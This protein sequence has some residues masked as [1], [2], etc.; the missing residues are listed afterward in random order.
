MTAFYPIHINIEGKKCLIVGGGKTAERKVSTLVRYGGKV[1]VISPTATRVSD[2]NQVFLVFSATDSEELNREICR[3]AKERGILINVVDSPEDCDFISPSLVER[4]HLKISISTE[5]LAPLLSKRIR[6]DLEKSFG[7]EYRQYTA[8][9]VKVRSAILKNKKLNNQ[10]KREKLDRL[11]S[12][13]IID[14]LRSGEKV[15]C[16]TILKQLGVSR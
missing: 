11:L 15:Y 16:K 2:L 4:G 12:L 7:N 9:I 10:D 1:V 6:K 8:L 14:K 3:E 5:G 13:N